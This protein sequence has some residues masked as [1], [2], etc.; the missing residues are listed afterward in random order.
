MVSVAIIG[1]LASIAIPAFRTYQLKSKR[2]EAYANLESIARMETAYFAEYSIFT[3]ALPSQPGSLATYQRAWTPAAAS[4]FGNLGWL[5]EG[6]VYF[7]Y[8]TNVDP[9]ECPQL[10]CFTAAAYGDLDGD[11]LLSVVVYVQRD[12]SGAN[13]SETGV[14]LTANGVIMPPIEP[15]SGQAIYSQV[16]V[17]FSSDRF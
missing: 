3:A 7:D 1:V 14:D 13:M 6:P 4:V 10:D 12:A 2:S 15:V 8:D 17:H 11:G 9:T 16:A 5:P